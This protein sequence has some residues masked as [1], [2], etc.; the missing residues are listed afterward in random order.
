MRKIGFS[1]PVLILIIVAFLLIEGCSLK[2]QSIFMVGMN[3]TLEDI[4]YNQIAK[5]ALEAFNDYHTHWETE[6]KLTRSNTYYL[7][8]IQKALTSE[9]GYIW[10]LEPEMAEDVQSIARQN[11]TRN[12]II[13][14]WHPEDP[15]DYL[16]NVFYI[17][18]LENEGSFLMGV[19]AGNTTES[20]VVGFVG[21]LKDETGARYEAGFRAGLAYS[22]PEAKVEVE[23]IQSRSDNEK[24][25]T[26]ATAMV[27][28]GADVIYHAA[29]E[30]GEGIAGVCRDNDIWFIG[31]DLDQSVL[32][33]DHT[34][35]CMLKRIDM[36]IALTNR[37]LEEGI[38]HGGEL[39]QIGVPEGGVSFLRSSS[40]SMEM[41][42]LLED[43][44]YHM[45]SGELWITDNPE[46]SPLFEILSPEPDPDHDH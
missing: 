10:S 21:G 1:L 4:S 5:E 11:P 29:G 15:K 6:F 31:S 36:A 32:A 23:Y 7:D 2:N 12:F 41:A 34:L 33:P 37:D 45:S 18:Y 8:A 14:D 39:F 3:R 26:A 19:V 28:A 20:D 30:A 22:N 17:S 43:I 24:A 27:A 42:H 44:S 46:E 9:A 38:F 16:K 13:V 25:A 35:T 40:L